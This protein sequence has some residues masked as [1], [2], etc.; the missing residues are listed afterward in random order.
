[1]LTEEISSMRS[2]RVRHTFSICSWALALLATGTALGAAP[3]PAPARLE[4]VGIR[5]GV[6]DVGGSIPFYARGFGFELLEQGAGSATLRNGPVLL[7]LRKVDEGSRVQAPG[8][9][10]THAVFQVRNLKRALEELGKEKVTVVETRPLPT[11]VGIFVTIKDLSGNIQQLLELTPRDESLTRPKVFNFR[12]AVTDI[13]KAREFY[14]GKLGFEPSAAESDPSALTLEKAGVAPIVLQQTATRRS[15]TEYPRVAQTVLLMGTDDLA[16][17]MASLKKKGIEFLGPPRDS[18]LG[19]YVSFLDPSGNVIELLQED[20]VRTAA[21]PMADPGQAKSGLT[22]EPTVLTAEDGT[23]IDAELGRLAVPENRG[24]PA[25]R[26]VELAFVRLKSTARKPGPP[27]VYLAGGPGGSGIAATRG[28]RLPLFLALRELGDVIAL[29]Q[30]GT[31]MSRPELTCS[32]SWS[33]PL[34]RP[35]DPEQI[36]TQAEE[37]SWTCNRTLRAA[38]IDLSSY[39]TNESADDLEDLRQAL[40]VPKISLLGISYGTHLALAMIRRHESSLQSVVLAGVEG[41]DQMLRLPS[42]LEKQLENVSDLVRSD[43]EVGAA[44]PSLPAALKKL[45]ARLEDQPATVEVD[46]PLANRK[47]QVTVGK[48]DLQWMTVQSLGSREGLKK[49]PRKI[50]AMEKGDFRSLGEFA[51]AARRGWLGS[52]IPYVVQCA[53][54]ASPERLERIKREEPQ[55][56]LGGAIDFPFPTICEVW[57]VPDLGAAFRAPVHSSVPALFISGSLDTRTPEGDAEEVRR[58]FSRG[59][60]LTIDGACHGDDLLLSSPEI[61]RLI[62]KFLAGETVTDTRIAL[63]PLKFEPAG[64]GGSRPVPA[65]SPR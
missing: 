36:L 16:A 7:G 61:G 15:G 12:V 33:S 21:R 39:N 27:I 3:P 63:A 45:F 59:I 19:R 35:S 13:G 23:R 50:L 41:P 5:V 32:G 56:L 52:A 20:R 48:F 17:G 9:A 22:L 4:I 58:H 62:V 29:D 10:E 37:R 8:D 51:V 43:S 49:L 64:E 65:I 25:G 6:T 1:M 26:S 2:D 24:K 42:T 53:S 47:A 60:H 34:D 14:C 55:T 46:V 40:G 18:P 38:G 28:S 44:V 11:D 57:G 54:G 30:R 31:G